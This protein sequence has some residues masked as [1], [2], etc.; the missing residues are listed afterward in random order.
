MYKNRNTKNKSKKGE[1][2]KMKRILKKQKRNN[3]NCARDYGDCDVNNISSSNQCNNRPR[4]D[5]QPS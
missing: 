4:R 2:K 3:A 5:I 1:V